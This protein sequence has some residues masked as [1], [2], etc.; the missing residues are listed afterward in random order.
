MERLRKTPPGAKHLAQLATH[1]L[2]AWE[3][4]LCFVP[5][6][7]EIQQFDIA[8]VWIDADNPVCVVSPMCWHWG[9]VLGPC[10][11]LNSYVCAADA[12][13]ATKDAT[14]YLLLHQRLAWIE[15]QRGRVDWKWFRLQMDHVNLIHKHLVR[16]DRDADDKRYD[17]PELPKS[18]PNA[19]A[20]TRYFC[21]QTP[22]FVAR[23]QQ[24]YPNEPNGPQLRA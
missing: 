15:L 18:A 23:Y 12:Q 19:A 3:V 7:E 21:P 10:V 9:V 5:T 20:L 4:A 24:L 14:D 2:T 16:W 8:V 6:D 1:P 17:P 13:Q 22:H 11:T